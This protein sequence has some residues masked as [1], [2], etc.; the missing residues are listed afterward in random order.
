MPARPFFYDSARARPRALRLGLLTLLACI[1][2]RA[3]AQSASAPAPAPAPAADAEVRAAPRIASTHG[4]D[5]TASGTALDLTRRITTPRSLGDVVRE[6]P[7][8]QVV[9]TGGMGAFS[10]VSLRGADRE[11]SLVLLDEIPLSTPDGGAFDLSQFPAEL[12]AR[13]N[14]FRGGAPVW[15]GSGAIGGVVQLVPQRLEQNVARLA[16]GAGSYGTWQLHGGTSVLLPAGWT[17]HAQLVVRGTQGDFPFYY[18]GTT[19]FDR[20][21][22]RTLRRANADWQEATGLHD[23]T[24]P[25]LGGTLHVLALGTQRGGGIP[26]PGSS[27]TQDVRRDSSRALLALAYDR[28][29]GGQRFHRRTQVVVSGAYGGERLTDVMGELGINKFR[30]TDDHSW[31]VFARAA[32]TLSLTSWLDTTCVASYALDAYLPVDP[33]AFPAPR[34]SLR[35]TAAPALELALHGKTGAVRYELRPSARLEW[36]ATEIDAT[37]DFADRYEPRQR[38]LVPTV[39]VGGVV[40]P[41]AS[42]AFSASYATGKRVPTILELFGDRG[43]LLPAF[44]LTPVRSQTVDG[45]ASWRGRFWNVRGSAELRGFYQERRGAIALASTSQ[46]TVRYEN[47]SRVEQWG[48]ESGLSGTIGEH[49]ALAGAFTWLETETATGKRLAFRPRFV[50]Y[51]RPE[52]RWRFE[53]GWVSGASLSAEAARR[54]FVFT[55]PANTTY[56]D[57]CLKVALGAALSLFAERVRL[58][59]RMDDV[60]DARCTDLL[61]YPLPG[62]SLFFSLTF[63]EVLNDRS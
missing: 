3:L 23:L 18:D 32:H 63:Q 24:V 13:V 35:Q 48:L 34:R 50:S 14:V 57:A 12:F 20:T 6:S 40:A 4:S 5:P 25:L 39:R 27:P 1:P 30:A 41:R 28:E 61:G 17:S 44:D 31:R 45:G 8:A 2:A 46:R 42:F 43:L 19:P 7:G 37:P 33:L 10:A 49:V 56:V 22:D 54:S 9:N 26:G 52:A 59:A 21:D 62:R 36:S 11:E 53:R 29:T 38:V 60:A 58:S 15:L 16:L 55:D 51:V 47:L